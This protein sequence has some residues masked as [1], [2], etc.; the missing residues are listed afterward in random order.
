ML[1]A[2]QVLATRDAAPAGEVSPI[3]NGT[4]PGAELG[5][6][7]RSKSDTLERVGDTEEFLDAHERIEC[8][9]RN[10]A[11][12]SVEELFDGAG[13]LSESSDVDDPDGEVPEND[14]DTGQIE[15]DHHRAPLRRDDVGGMKVAVYDAGDPWGGGCVL[16]SLVHRGNNCV[17]KPGFGGS[18]RQIG[19]DV[20]SDPAHWIRGD[21]GDCCSRKVMEAA[22]DAAD[23]PPI[24]CGAA[25]YHVEQFPEHPHRVRNTNRRWIS[26]VEGME[27]DDGKT[28][29]GGEQS[30]AGL[31]L[32]RGLGGG[33]RE[34]D[35]SRSP[36][37]SYSDPSISR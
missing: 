14:T 17:A 16:L 3:T 31:G 35:H 34:A 2:R 36:W 33:R 30:H 6:R 22:Q 15:V 25:G 20:R 21:V 19:V 5:I 29:V 18:A 27:R 28:M 11:A 23:P 24:D 13:A 7:W 26:A 37:H 4:H 12:V 1:L 10:S 9:Q 8:L 32:E